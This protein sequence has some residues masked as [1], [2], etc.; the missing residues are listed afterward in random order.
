MLRNL[1]KKLSKI[2]CDYTQLPQ[3]KNYPSQGC[4]LRHFRTGSKPSRWSITAAKKI[5]KKRNAKKKPEKP[6]DV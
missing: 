5:R 4:F 3:G 6:Q 2:S 1:I